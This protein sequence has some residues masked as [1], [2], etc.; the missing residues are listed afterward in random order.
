[1][2]FKYFHNIFLIVSFIVLLGCGKSESY[3]DRGYISEPTIVSSLNVLHTTV[4]ADG[5]KTSTLVVTLHD[6]EGNAVIDANVTLSQTGNSTIGTVIN[7]HDG[8]YVFMV[9]SSIIETVTYTVI[10]NSSSTEQMG[11]VTFTDKPIDSDR[12]S[13]AVSKSSV[14][15]DNVDS[16][17]ITVTL[18][19]TEGNAVTDANVTLSQAGSS[20]IGAV[21]NHHDG[22]YTFVVHSS[23]AE[24]VT[25]TAIANGATVTQTG[26]V[27]FIV[28]PVDS[29][30]SS[31]SVSKSSVVADDV[32]SS[33]VTVTLQDTQGNAVTDANIT[34]SQT[35]SS[36]MDAVVNHHD[37]N[38]S[39]VVHSSTIETV[40]YTATANGAT[41]TQTGEV[42]FTVGPIDINASSLSVSHASIV[43][44]NIEVST[45]TVTFQDAQGNAVTDANVTLSQTGSSTIGAVVNHHDGTYTF[46]VHSSY[47]ETVTYTAIANGV[48]VTQTGDVIFQPSGQVVLKAGIVRYIASIDDHDYLPYMPAAGPATWDVKIS[49][50]GVN[51]EYL[52]E[53]GTIN[54]TGINIYIPYTV[55]V[56]PVNIPA[57]SQTVH[58]PAEYTQDDTERDIILSYPAQTLPVGSGTIIATAKSLSGI[59]NIKKL[60]I[61]S[62]VGDLS[63]TIL[64]NNNTNQTKN[65]LGVNV[66]TFTI[67][68]NTAGDT[69]EIQLRAIAG[70]PD[71]N[72]GIPDNNGDPESHSFLY[73]PVKSPTGKIW[74]NNNLGADYSNF[75]HSSFDLAQQA[76]SLTDYHAFGSLFQW[77]RKADGHELVQ[78]TSSTDAKVTPVTDVKSNNPAHAKFIERDGVSNDWR[79]SPDN[80]LWRGVNAPNA[81]CPYG[82]RLPTPAEAKA[83][84]NRWNGSSIANNAFASP[85][86]ILISGPRLVHGSIWYNSGRAYYNTTGD[87]FYFY[88][89]VYDAVSRGGAWPNNERCVGMSTRCIKN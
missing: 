51:D 86:K 78:W 67:T 77:G 69:G 3:I 27:T 19:D 87:L 32:D 66:A 12:S 30:V 17:T 15:A 85:L 70:I 64:E 68:L 18:Q 79:V 45:I 54:T 74:L 61:N 46:V 71:R 24:T 38:Y 14:V 44:D 76:T 75:K 52:E 84:L 65:V 8:T 4:V 60:D 11:D 40:T 59:L 43:A 55:T 35:G 7:N 31:L 63:D 50:D 9:Y 81:V 36:T 39:C 89:H 16:A 72:L 48:T 73:L 25:Y 83:E 80:S 20:I 21:V 56:R 49:A 28:G 5:T 34:L 88:S 6:T 42:R 26:D 13:I 2:Y 62:G 22:I 23:Y 41:V 57:Y 1:M 37:G 33:T 29:N 53:Q 47:A 58:V 82:Y 10:V